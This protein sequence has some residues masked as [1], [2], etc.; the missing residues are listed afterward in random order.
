MTEPKSIGEWSEPVDGLRGRLL[1][2]ENVKD[3]NGVRIGNIYLELQNLSSGDN[4]YVYYDAK[5][6]PIHCELNDS[7]S[8]GVKVWPGNMSDGMPSACWLAL[9]YDSSLRFDTRLGPAF[10]PSHPCLFIC[11]G[12]EG[13]T[14]EIPLTA[15]N[16]FYLSGT[17]TT[18]PPQNETRPHMWE[19]TLKLPPVKI[20][21]KN[22]Q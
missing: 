15:T 6:S 22:S 19:G 20:S 10:T 1:F 7:K 5:K 8:D 11:I 12:L 16:D 4:R 2:A 9:P 13:G 18:T 3:E 17:F 21:V 14:W